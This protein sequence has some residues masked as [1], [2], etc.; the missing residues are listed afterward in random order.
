MKTIAK[1]ITQTP[2]KSLKK[3]AKNARTHSDEQILQIASSI[4]EFGFANPIL[5]DEN[6]RILAGHGRYMA[7]KQLGLKTVPTVVLEGL[8]QAQKKAFVIADNKIA[9]N[10]GWDREL[11]ISEIADLEDVNFNL[12]LLGFDEDEIKAI[13]EEAEKED[14]ETEPETRSQ[15]KLFECPHCHKKF[16]LSQASRS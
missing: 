5:T 13:L 10:A 7:A 4:A 8:S 2:I 14:D 12:D 15:V 11:L 6:G 1:K 16:E 3:Y 9:E